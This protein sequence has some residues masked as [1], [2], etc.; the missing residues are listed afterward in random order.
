LNKD[1]N[2]NHSPI[3]REDFNKFIYIHK[4]AINKAIVYDRDYL[5]EYLGFQT[6]CDGYLLKIDD[7]VIERPQDLIMRVAIQIY[8]PDNKNDF[9]DAS[10]NKIFHAYE[11]M[12][13][14]YYTHATPTL[15]NSGIKNANLSSCFLLN[16][17]DSLDS[18]MKIGHDTANISKLSGGV[19]FHISNI[20]AAGSTIRGTNG[21]SK[22]IVPFLKIYNDI[23][24]AFDQG[25]GKRK[26]SFA[27]YL[28]MHHPDIMN[29]LKLRLPQGVEEL[30]TK[31]LFI[32]LWVSDCGII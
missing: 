11:M 3:I 12:S 14:L 28:E 15:F 2:G 4:D 13:L 30:R 21:K 19:G 9:R 6:L 20:R 22:G 16:I 10:L 23:A 18:I 32:A 1:K 27:P 8:I 25:G 29:F 5:F 26:G 24:K 17:D 31:D 7:N